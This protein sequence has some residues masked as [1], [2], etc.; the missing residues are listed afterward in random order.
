M[1]TRLLL[2]VGLAFAVSA[3][4]R[5]DDEEKI[6]AAKKASQN[7]LKQIA[8]G[9]HAC[10]D[11]NGAIPHNS[12]NKDGKLL[13]SWRVAILP[14]LEQEALYKEFKLDEAWDSDH[15]KKLIEKMPKVFEAVIGK[16]EKGH[17]FYQGYTGVH[18]AFE[19]KQKM[20]IAQFTDGLS[21]TLL[22]VEGAKSIE[23]TKPDDL[24]AFDPKKDE[25][26]KVGGTLFQDGFH[27]A[28]GDG[29]VKFLKAD[30]D[31]KILR[32]MITRNG[33]EVIP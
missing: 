29:S 30:L 32:A 8:L 2:G 27:A 7:N 9:V 6:A 12:T 15:N 25:L 3:S 1:L 28:M 24:L 11:V 5:A 31:K 20:R 10:H 14:Y 4:V 23:W 16:A 33:G 19:E 22:V 21:N 17:T 26:P 18:T 13:L